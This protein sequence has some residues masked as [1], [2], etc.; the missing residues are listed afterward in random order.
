MKKSSKNGTSS[1]AAK[2]NIQSNM[3][4][5]NATNTLNTVASTSSIQTSKN[6]TFLGVD[7]I[8]YPK[9]SVKNVVQPKKARRA[10]LNPTK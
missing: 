5:S 2:K 10:G 8:L 1:G 3:Q 6:R 9:E 7:S 4:T